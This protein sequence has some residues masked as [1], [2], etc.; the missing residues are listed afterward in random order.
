[1]YSASPDML[2]PCYNQC[3]G[4]SCAVLNFVSFIN[5]TVVIWSLCRCKYLY[6]LFDDSFLVNRNYIFTTEGHPLP[7]LSSWH[8]RLPEAYIPSNWT[9]VQVLLPFRA[10]GL[11]Y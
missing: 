10:F 1:M 8:E 4:I 7:I 11:L 9:S 6:L 5:K 3:F 2:S